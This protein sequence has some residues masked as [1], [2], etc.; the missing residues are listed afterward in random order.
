MPKVTVASIGLTISS[1]SK[2][3]EKVS[4]ILEQFKKGVPKVMSAFANVSLNAARS[5]A[6]VGQEVFYDKKGHI[7]YLRDPNQPVLSENISINKS[8]LNEFSLTVAG[9]GRLGVKAYMQEYG[10]PYSTKFGPYKPNPKNHREYNGTPARNIRRVGY[11]RAGMIKAS[12]AMYSGKLNLSKSISPA[13]VRNYEAVVTKNLNKVF[14]NLLL[15]YATGNSARLP[16]Y[17][18]NK[19]EIPTATISKFASKFGSI[20][21]LTI[22]IPIEIELDS[23]VF[24]TREIQRGYNF[25]K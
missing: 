10:Y 7:K 5:I 1:K 23:N 9:G 12:E 22:N 14:S 3:I 6:P 11:L 24:S 19:V 4:A 8:G 17:F 16:N 25:L 15:A 20:K 2:E 13:D 21:G 18:K